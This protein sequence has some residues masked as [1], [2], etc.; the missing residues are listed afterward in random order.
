MSPLVARRKGIISDGEG[1]S[2]GPF[3]QLEAKS[4]SDILYEPS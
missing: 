3:S 2:G 4:L 1:Q